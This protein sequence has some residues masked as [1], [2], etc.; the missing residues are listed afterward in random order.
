MILTGS[1]HFNGESEPGMC[2]ISRN[3]TP[4]LAKTAWPDSGKAGDVYIVFFSEPNVLVW[5]R[6]DWLDRW[7]NPRVIVVGDFKTI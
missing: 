7:D 4:G 3:V 1:R 5:A 2:K 6:L